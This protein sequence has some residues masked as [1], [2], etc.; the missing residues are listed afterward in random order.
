MGLKY[1]SD[2]DSV[3]LISMGDVDAFGIRTN[4][5]TKQL[6]KCSCRAIENSSPI[7]SEGGRQVIPTYSVS[8]NGKV[9]VNI[10]DRLEIDGVTKTILTKKESKDL[11]RKVLFT[12]VTL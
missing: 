6:L 7:E 9:A 4:S 11:S 2:K 12:K 8:F 5:E 10:G 3:Y 1:I